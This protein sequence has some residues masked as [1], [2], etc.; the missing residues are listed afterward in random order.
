MKFFFIHGLLLFFR[1]LLSSFKSSFPWWSLA[2]VKHG[3]PWT[4]LWWWTAAA[5]ATTT[6]ILL[7]NLSRP[8][9]K[10]ITWLLT[11]MRYLI[12][13]WLS[14]LLQWYV[15]TTSNWFINPLSRSARRSLA[16]LGPHLSARLAVPA[17]LLTIFA[18]SSSRAMKVFHFF[19]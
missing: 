9:C 10:T 14:L 5:S 7:R 2:L 3:F 13:P 18:S 11:T 17:R 12:L 16:M 19:D 1:A 8:I 15:Y 6:L 4:S